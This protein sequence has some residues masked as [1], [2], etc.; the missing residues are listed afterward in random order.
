MTSTGGYSGWRWI[1]II[2]GLPAIILAVVC[3]VYLANDAN[4]A[5]FLNQEERNLVAARQKALTG[6]TEVFDWADSKKVLKDWKTYLFAVTQFCNA[7][8][9][10]SYSTFLP[11]MILQ[12][13][14]NSGRAIAQ[15]LTMPC[16]AVGATVYL[17]LA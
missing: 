17:S 9:L 7:C 10:Y 4:N 16:Y 2:E 15:L 5:Y 8:M 14:P 13:M 6:V 12:I 1:L 11:T 3:W